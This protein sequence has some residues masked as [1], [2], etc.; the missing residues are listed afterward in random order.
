LSQRQRRLA[1]I[2]FTDMAGYTALGQ[3]NE[4][5]SLALVEEQRKLVRP[6]LGRHSGRE[7]KTMGDAFL[8]EFPSALDAVRCAYDIQRATREFNVSLS[9]EQRLHLRI[10]VHLGDVVESQGDISGDAVNVASR[11]EP[12]AED[13]GV[14]LSRQVYDHVQNK[15]ELPLVSMG[16]KSLKN[17]STGIEV[18]KMAMPWDGE[19]SPSALGLDPRRVAVLPFASMSPDPNDSYFAEGITE[20]II[21]TISSVSGLSVISRTSVMGY[22]G[23]TKR[24]KEIGK[25]LDAGTVLEGSFR[26]AGDKIRVTAQLIDV[27]NDSHVWA[28]SYDRELHDIF[29]VQ[30]DIA[31]RIADALE[32]R[33]LPEERERMEK[34]PTKNT[35]AYTLYLKGRHY[36][37]DRTEASLRT[38]MR[39]FEK[40]IEKDPNYA[41]AFAGIADCYTV[42]IGHGYMRGSEGHP[43]AMEF[44]SKA[45][46]LD[47]ELGEAHTT[48]A[49]LLHAEWRWAEAEQ[50]FKRALELNP[51]YATAHHWYSQLLSSRGRMDEAIAE[52]EKAHQLDPNSLQILSTLGIWTFYA[53]DVDKAIEIQK[54]VLDVDPDFL[55]G[56]ANLLHPYIAKNMTSEAKEIIQKYLRL[57]GEPQNLLGPYAHAYAEV[58]EI[59]EARST[60]AEIRRLGAEAYT[61]ALDVA[62]AYWILNEGDSA[63][64]WLGKALDEK[65]PGLLFIRVDPDYSTLIKDSRV[66]AMLRRAG[67]P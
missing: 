29:A 36:W 41:L 25:E 38:A 21:S 56:L 26:K 43:R 51:S 1:A 30:T 32:V 9:A 6:I 14:C 50:E 67:L 58:G 3:R 61:S 45:L 12:L 44:V 48:L 31:K 13:G 57:V 63:L 28:Q 4:S 22:K 40:A 15:F 11:I 42:L 27:N 66:D 39:Y 17:I 54:R 2:M 55:P 7:V 52:I 33:I 47:N 59:E 19:A 23:T 10:G 8:V 5:L 60:L 49:T 20:E 16:T 62:T 53:R 34:A 46:K 18:F 37:N 24:V 35:E 64:E 65:D